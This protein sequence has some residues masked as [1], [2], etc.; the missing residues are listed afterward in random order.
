[1][2]INRLKRAPAVAGSGADKLRCSRPGGTNKALIWFLFGVV[3]LLGVLG[4]LGGLVGF[5]KVSAVSLLH[6]RDVSPDKTH[7]AIPRVLCRA[8]C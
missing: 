3:L 7:I 2:A 8:D 1:M 6:S 4:V 5:K